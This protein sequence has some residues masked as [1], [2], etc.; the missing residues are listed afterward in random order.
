MQRASRP[1]FLNFARIRFPVGA[2]ASIGHRLSGLMLVLAL[3]FG[4]LALERSFSDEAAFSSLLEAARSP[5][6][7]MAVVLIA[8]GCAHHVLAG[9]RHLLSDVG[10]GASLAAS[11]A[12]AYVVLVAA[13]ALGAVAAFLP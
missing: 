5:A 11:R 13:A 9:I 2:I 3:P 8:W 6:G 1:V 4:V 10:V 7:R 12:S